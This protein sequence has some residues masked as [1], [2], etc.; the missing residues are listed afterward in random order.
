MTAKRKGKTAKGG[1]RKIVYLDG[2]RVTKYLHLSKFIKVYI[3]VS[4]FFILYH[5][6]FLLIKIIMKSR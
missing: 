2:N 4:I 5:N 6:I 1:N 3:Q